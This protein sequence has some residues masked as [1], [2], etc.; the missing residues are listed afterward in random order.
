[1]LNMTLKEMKLRVLRKKSLSLSLFL[2]GGVG[3]V[4]PGQFRK[5]RTVG[6]CPTHAAEAPPITDLQQAAWLM[7]QMG[8]IALH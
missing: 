3:Q 7:E 1:M 6:K 2:S 5:A 8:V 4:F